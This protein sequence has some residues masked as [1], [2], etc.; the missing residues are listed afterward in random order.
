MNKTTNQNPNANTHGHA[1]KKPE[2]K[3]DIDSRSGEEQ[4]FKGDDVTNNT[5]EK[6]SETSKQKHER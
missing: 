5:K 2:N 4:T 3:D 1:S 6:H